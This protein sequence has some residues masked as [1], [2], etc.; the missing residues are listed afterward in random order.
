M[1]TR[2][3][4]KWDGEERVVISLA[5]ALGIVILAVLGLWLWKVVAPTAPAL[6]DRP[7]IEMP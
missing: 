6:A 3:S 5:I 1:L 7:P 2:H 4:H